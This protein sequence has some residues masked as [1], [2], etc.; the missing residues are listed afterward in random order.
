MLKVYRTAFQ[1]CVADY[2]EEDAR[3]ERRLRV[4][5]E[6]LT[7]DHL[8]VNPSCRN[9]MTLSLATSELAKVNSYRAPAD[10][11][12]CV[13]RC[14]SFLFNQLGLSRTDEGARPGADDFLPVF[15]YVVLHSDVPQ[16]H[17]N[18]EYI[19][20]YRNPRALM[21]KAGYCLVNLQSAM[22]FLT[23][24]RAESLTGIGTQEEL[25]ALVAAAE[26]KLYPPPAPAAVTE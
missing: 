23:N 12:Q 26:A 15:I 6:V 8:D 21:S 14:A 13:V 22:A 1:T 10:K 2:R 17:A 18:V 11:A 20:S 16:L 9:Q 5:R 24:V 7:P 25:D 4:L 3:F 19:N